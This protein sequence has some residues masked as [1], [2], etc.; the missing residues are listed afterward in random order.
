MRNIILFD[1]DH[2]VSDAFWRDDM[3]K[4]SRDSGNWEEYHSRGKED[5]PLED[6]VTLINHI[7]RYNTHIEAWG[8]TARPEKWRKQSMDWFVK[9]KIMLDVI[10]MRPEDAFKPAPQIKIDLCREHDILD[11]VL[12]IFDDR[13]DVIEAF[14]ELGITAFHV[15]SRRSSSTASNSNQAKSS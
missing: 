13:E 4:R 8:I 5:K 15:H 14:K 6:M 3:I 2:V 1:I 7:A 11:R 10:L 9:H 12:C